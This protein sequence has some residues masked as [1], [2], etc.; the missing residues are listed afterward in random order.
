MVKYSVFFM[1]LACV[2]SSC[3][4]SSN[5]ATSGSTSFVQ[6]KAGSYFIFDE[7]NIDTTSGLPIPGS[8]DTS[9]HTFMQTGITYMGKTNVSMIISTS[10]ISRDTIIINYESNGD[11]SLFGPTF[12]TNSMSW[13]TIPT[14]SKT[15]RTVTFDTTIGSGG[16]SEEMKLTLTFSFVDNE[17][18]TIKG[19]SI[20]VTKIKESTTYTTI[21]AGVSNSQTSN[22]FL[23]AAPSLGY[24]AK[25]ETPVQTGL[26]GGG[27]T[28]GQISMLIDY[29]LK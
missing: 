27:R 24:V 23:Y 19:Q 12:P 7:Y 4:N 29:S 6:P 8:R 18:L 10:S 9:T 15:S 26:Y 11:I 20:S 22:S 14:E 13:I 1:I 17:N 3:S 2:I 16:F 21:I 5:P 28:E 25:A